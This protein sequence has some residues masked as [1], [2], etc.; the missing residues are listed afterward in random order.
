MT[1]EDTARILAYIMEHPGSFRQEIR[2][3]LGFEKT[4]F[5]NRMIR[6][7]KRRAIREEPE[8]LGGT[9]QNRVWIA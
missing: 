2:A 4:Y 5:D 6:L 7:K 1:E 3:A 8:P 9:R